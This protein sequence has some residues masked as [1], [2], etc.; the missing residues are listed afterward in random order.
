MIHRR[1]QL[2]S[3]AIVSIKALAVYWLLESLL[4]A[5]D[6]RSEDEMLPM[7]VGRTL[8]LLLIVGAAARF[9]LALR[10]L[11]FV[12]AASVLAVGSSLPGI[13]SAS[14][15]LTLMLAVGLVI[16]AAIVAS[17]LRNHHTAS[18]RS[19]RSASF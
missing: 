4:E 16:K 13:A 5:L 8:W 15:L 14:P 12:C 3:Y 1:V 6:M 18:E 2:S 19:I 9:S 10:L 11:T 17:L 7:L